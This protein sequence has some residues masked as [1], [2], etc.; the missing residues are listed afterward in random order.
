ME[1]VLSLM[2]KAAKAYF[3]L[4]AQDY[5]WRYTGNTYISQE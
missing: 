5:A 4:A 2:K 1:R 3:K